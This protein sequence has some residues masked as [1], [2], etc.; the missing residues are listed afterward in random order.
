MQSKSHAQAQGK[1][2][3]AGAGHART[4]GPRQ[5]NTRVQVR[6]VCQDKQASRITNAQTR[7]MYTHIGAKHAHAHT[8]TKGTCSASTRAMALDTLLSMFLVMTAALAP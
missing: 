6:V 1:H 7:T 3:Q 5:H 2:A 4:N 8:H